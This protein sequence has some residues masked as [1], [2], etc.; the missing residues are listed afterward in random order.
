MAT[1]KDLPQGFYWR[2]TVIWIRTDPITGG[3]RSTGARTVDGAYAYLAERE[4]VSA[5]PLHRAAAEATVAEWARKTC[6]MKAQTK[7]EGT[8]QMYDQKLGHV[9]RIFGGKSPMTVIDAPAVDKFIAQRRREGVKDNTIQRELTC[10]MQ[11]L[12]LARRGGAYH[13]EISQVKPIGF[14]SGYVPK[15][16]HLEPDELPVLLAALTPERAAWVCMAIATGGDISDV[17][18]IQ[19]GDYDPVHQTIQLR[20]TKN[21]FRKARIPVPDIFL[22]LLERALPFLPFSWPRVS[23]DIPETCERI[24]ITRV[25]PKDLR[26]TAATWLKEGGVALDTLGRWLRHGGAKVAFDVYDRSAPEA[27]GLAI[28][29]QMQ[30]RN[31]V[32][33]PLA[34]QADAADLKAGAAA[35]DPQKTP[36]NYTPSTRWNPAR[37]A[38]ADT[39]LLQ[40]AEARARKLRPLVAIDPTLAAPLAVSEAVVEAYH[41]GAG[42]PD[43]SDNLARLMGQTAEA[44]GL[45][46]PE[47]VVPGS[48]VAP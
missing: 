16:T 4:R 11:M 15:D 23:K 6:E 37:Q 14:S 22:D 40:R 28:R 2:G 3:A 5:S 1:R 26:R 7:S 18:R 47:V 38:A 42:D 35:G 29:E 36:P 45:S 19:P 20:G 8:Q 32:H 41:L 30:K 27:T 31:T 44:L 25:T 9:V 48:E 17:E 39:D 10:L 43:A 46:D 12:K 24:G 21:R 33:G 13:L 34:K